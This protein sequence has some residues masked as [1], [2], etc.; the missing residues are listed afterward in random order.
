MEI[1][2]TISELSNKIKTLK[3]ALIFCHSRPDGDTLSSAFSLKY[4][5]QKTGVRA[6][7]TCQDEIPEKYASLN[8]FDGFSD[9][10]QGNVYDAHI[11]VDC[12]N[13]QM[14]GA[15]YNLFAKNKQTFN[16]DHHISNTR[17]AKYNF[18]K[19]ECANTVNIYNLIVA[20]G[21]EIDE[22]LAN[23]LYV[24][25]MTDS[26]NFSQ[27]NT[28]ANA[29]TVAS[30]LVK[31]GATPDKLYN[32][33]FKNQPISRAKLYLDV[34]QGL[35]LYHEGRL[36][37]IKIMQ[38]DLERYNLKSEVTEGFIDFPQ[39]IDSVEVAI[40]I[41]QKS[42]KCFKISFRSKS[43]VNVNEIASIFGGGGH[44][45]ASGAV[46][47]GRL[48]DVVDKLVFNVGNYL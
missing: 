15:N 44:V 24:G 29:L 21:I 1:M 4:A 40:S 10:V 2:M 32:K 42:D 20:M 5:L 30:E 3:S 43:Y 27:S 48:E 12:A 46:L 13:E 41:L 25:I 28:D 33:L 31:N 8:L 35:R 22:K 6:E 23:A 16:I 18:V 34:M 36:A 14:I 37:I 9:A 11:S 47:N 38:S 17:Y 39:T 26:G 19:N 7:V 45:R